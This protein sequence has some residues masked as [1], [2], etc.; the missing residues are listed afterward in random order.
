[1]KENFDKIIRHLLEF[2]GGYVN[3]PDD[4]GGETKYGISKSAWPKEDIKNLTVERASEIYRVSYWNAIKG[5]ELPDKIDFCVM[6]AAVNSGV[7]TALKILKSQPADPQGYLFALESYYLDITKKRPVL[8]KY[9]WDW[10]Y[11]TCSLRRILWE[12]W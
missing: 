7:G 3:D 9:L 12:A 6:N 1:M 8:K 10:F 4:P 11:R 5:D 2:E